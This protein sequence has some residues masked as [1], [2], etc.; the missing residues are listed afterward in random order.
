[1]AKK[2]SL[3][4]ELN[5]KSDTFIKKLNSEM[6]YQSD[7]SSGSFD[8]DW[9]SKIDLACPYLDNIV[10]NPKLMLIREEETVKV[11]KAKK[12]SVA[13]IKDLSRH[14][15]YID[16]IDEKTNEVSP[17]KIM[18]ERSEETF[19]TYENRFLYTLIYNV[20]RFINKKEEELEN[21][22]I[23][24]EKVLEYAATT[25]TGKEKVN[26]EFK[27]TSNEIPEE[28]EENIKE[29]K[30]Q[31]EIEKIKAQIQGI[32]A[33]VRSWQGSEMYTTLE[34]QRISLV[35]PPIKKTNLILKNPNFQVASKLWDFLQMYDDDKDDSSKKGLDTA[36][37]NTLKSILDDS[38]LMDFFVLDSISISKRE[39]K[40]RLAEYAVVLINQQLKRVISILLNSGISLT[41]EE[42]LEMIANELKKE[43]NKNLIDSSDIKNK[44][45]SA[46]EE[47]IEKS[48][49]YI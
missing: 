3:N 32:K 27:I 49:N 45:K 21:I 22:E 15:Q 13:S 10:R 18:I 40:K 31:Q 7:F 8:F 38:F 20:S 41:D 39:Q 35:S 2:I 43:R 1:M 12:I 37:N 19:N 23:R 5:N 46:I 9:V 25:S 14:T 47:Y 36:G 28:G 16:K 6:F 44:F 30:I 42:I 17:S 26:I 33:F 48:R 11:E 4:N 24:D 29:K 34:K